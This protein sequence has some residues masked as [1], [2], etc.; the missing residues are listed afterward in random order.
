MAVPT[1]LG[2]PRVALSS[3][4]AWMGAGWRQELPQER[5][6]PPAESLQ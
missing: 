2:Q 3:G 1:P 6:C 5:Y 4:R